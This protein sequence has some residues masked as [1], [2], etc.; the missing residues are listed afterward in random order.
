M[1]A[2]KFIKK[3]AYEVIVKK[4]VED[5]TLKE[6][7][8]IAEVSKQTFY[9]Y[10]KDKYELANEI[11]AQL[12]QQGI[13]EPEKIQ[14]EDDWRNLYL[15]QFTAFR[16]HMDFVRHLYSSRETGCTVDFEIASTIRFD[17]A[18]LSRKGADLKNPRIIFAIEAKD[19]GGTYA[20][21]DWILAGMQVEDE[22]MVERFRLIIPQIL[23]PYF[24]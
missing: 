9:R 23:V 6:I 5:V 7:L 20:M 19:V 14:N 21:R 10:Y 13:I 2:Q 18:I 16:E 12:T 11:Y 3:A 1:N 17:K 24:L 8:A 15:K 4:P 22:E